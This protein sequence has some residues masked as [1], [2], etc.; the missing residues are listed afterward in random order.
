MGWWSRL[1]SKTPEV[2]PRQ[3]PAIEEAVASSVPDG[4]DERIP[5]P[6]PEPGDAAADLLRA[7]RSDWPARPPDPATWAPPRLVLAALE[8]PSGQL[9]VALQL[10]AQGLP[11]DID[12]T[13]QSP[14]QGADPRVPVSEV[15]HLLW[16]YEGLQAVPALPPPDPAIAALVAALA[17]QPWH[18][19]DNWAQAAQVAGRLG[20]AAVPHLLAAMI[21][22][23]SLPA[24]TSALEWLPRLQVAAA[25]VVAQIDTGWDGSLRRSALRSLLL[26]P[27][28]WTTA[29]AVDVLARIARDEPE[30]AQDIGRLFEHRARHRCALGHWDWVDR[31]AQAWPAASAS[32]G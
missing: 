28:D 12:V 20:P 19:Q 3:E 22:P 2:A 10:A 25:Q 31:L 21:H 11:P 26:G 6:F 9:A 16:R 30:H 13:L 18:P 27:A 1:F 29:A 4:G 7:W 17:A 23:S 14:P 5:A 24:G 8:A 15:D 32:G